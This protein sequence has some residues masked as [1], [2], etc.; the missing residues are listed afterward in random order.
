M[1]FLLD[2]DVDAAVARMLRRRG[3]E[4]WTASTVGLADGGDDDLGVW[5]SE[6]R[7]AL[8]STDREFGRKRMRN[9]IGHHVWLV[10]PDWE[11]SDVLEIHLAKVLELLRGRH[12]ITF[13]VSNSLGVRASSRWD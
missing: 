10:C 7:A 1:R 11:A 4:C 8:V 5:A 6:H 2:Q 9:A 13:R 3:H 12:D